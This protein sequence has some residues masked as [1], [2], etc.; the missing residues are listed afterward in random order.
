MQEKLLKPVTSGWAV[1]LT[2]A[3]LLWATFVEFSN[4]GQCRFDICKMSSRPLRSNLWNRDI[5]HCQDE[6][7]A[8]K[9]SRKTV[10]IT[11]SILFV[12]VG[13]LVVGKSKGNKGT[14]ATQVQLDHPA[15]GELIEFVNAPADR[16][17]DQRG[18]PR[19]G[20]GPDCRVAF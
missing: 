19:Q 9:P 2:A 3:E 8:V 13:L 17:Q 6:R 11:G 20:L 4:R 1:R 5:S 16:T 12:I 18:D 10:I 14:Q 15:L 7:H